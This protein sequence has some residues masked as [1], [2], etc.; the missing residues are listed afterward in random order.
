MTPEARLSAAIEVLDTI[1]S[2]RKPA[3]QVLK[4]WGVAHRF[5]GSGDR[6]AIAD[7]VYACLRDGGGPGREAVIASLARH[8]KL[9]P[10]DIVILF[11]G[12]GYAPAALTPDEM[13]RLHA[14]ADEDAPASLPGFIS[15]QLGR[16]FG[17][18]MPAEV[19]ALLHG[20][21]PLDLRVNGLKSFLA[22][23]TAEL[24]DSGFSSTPTPYAATG[25]RLDASAAKLA[26]LDAFK[27][28]RFEVQDEGSQ[29]ASWL[30]G[31]EPGETVIDYCAGGGGKTLAI[32][33]AMRGEGRLI[34]CD[35]NPR[36]LE[37]ITP[38]L[39]RAGLTADL[40][41]VGPTGDRLDDL[42]GKADKVLV[43]APCSGSGTWRRR[44]EEAWR[45]TEEQLHALVVT[46]KDVLRRAAA[47][48]RP[49]GRLVY[50]TCS[51][52]AAENTDV[53]TSFAAEHR[54]F[55]PLPINQAAVSPL[56]TDAGRARL[57]E[58][59]SGGH[60]VQLSPRRTGTDAFFIALFQRSA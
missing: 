45:L 18:S 39:E 33:Q 1:A 17:K 48:V 46:Q 38:R 59:S 36:R 49:G 4:T 37:A 5:A 34:A 60:T 19:G 27:T 25:L 51:V 22:T 32:G 12:R 24:A 10:A 2:S 40:R 31:A 28:G 58:L 14:L 52:L 55:A 50:V 35:L 23:L 42:I 44:P 30:L 13:A 57:A 16:T 43:D 26:A 15:T 56:L 6:R 8:D 47:L 9:S 53:V 3:D 41:R 20:R 54:E 29:I 21:A 7:R 11:S